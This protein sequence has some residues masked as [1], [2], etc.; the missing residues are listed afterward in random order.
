MCSEADAT[1]GRNIFTGKFVMRFD[2][3]LL[4]SDRGRTA[5]AIDAS[6]LVDHG[7]NI[8]SRAEGILK[9]PAIPAKIYPVPQAAYWGDEI[10]RVEG[11]RENR[12]H[13]TLASQVC[14]LNQKVICRP[15]FLIKGRNRNCCCGNWSAER[16]G[17]KSR[18]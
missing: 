1:A 6:H 5:F 15:C 18:R 7:R 8:I 9:K 17:T 4:F 3:F 12:S 16:A 10:L 13:Y 11:I 14:H 2:R